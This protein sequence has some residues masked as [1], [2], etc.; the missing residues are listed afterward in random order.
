[1][2]DPKFKK[3]VDDVANHNGNDS[4]VLESGAV[5]KYLK[6]KGYDA[7]ILRE[8]GTTTY[9]VFGSDQLSLANGD[10]Q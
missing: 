1:L 4:W 5:K 8:N 9:A 7:M 10:K 6:S 3:F 2:N